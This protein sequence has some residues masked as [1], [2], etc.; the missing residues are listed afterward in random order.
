M[1]LVTNESGRL[2][3]RTLVL[4]VLLVTVPSGT[5]VR[6]ETMAV[7][8]GECGLYVALIDSCGWSLFD[9]FVLDDK[10]V[11]RANLPESCLETVCIADVT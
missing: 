1:W 3:Q 4:L 8:P 5:V 6:S 9:F 10:A 7:P 11:C 2:T